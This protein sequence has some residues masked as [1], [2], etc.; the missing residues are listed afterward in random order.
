MAMRKRIVR[1]YNF[2]WKEIKKNGISLPKSG[3][4]ENTLYPNW[5]NYLEGGFFS[6]LLQSAYPSDFDLHYPEF[7][8][9]DQIEW[10]LI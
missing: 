9:R 5:S 4:L 7:S 2:G 10:V 3:M 6:A 1:E 8:A